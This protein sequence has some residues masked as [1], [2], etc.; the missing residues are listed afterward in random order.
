[1]LN[2]LKLYRNRILGSEFIQNVFYL[3]SATAVAQLIPFIALPFLQKYFYSPADFGVFTVYVVFSELIISSAS[4]KYEYAIVGEKRLKNSSNLLFLSLLTVLFISLL[5]FIVLLLLY[6]LRVEGNV[7][8]ILGK[9]IFLVP[10]SVAAYGMFECFN[11][12][13]NRNQKFF[14]I[15]AGKAILSIGSESTKII[16]G[17]NNILSGLVLGRVT[18]QISGMLLHLIFFIR[19]NS[20]LIKL[21]SVRHI[22]K[23]G[24][25]HK[26]LPLFSTPS[27]L[28]GALISYIYINMF[29]SYYGQSVVGV[30]GVSVSY[31]A[32]AFSML[33]VS[34][35]QVFYR[36]ISD[37]GDKKALQKLYVRY[38]LILGT[39]SLGV[40]GI[41]YLIPSSLVNNLLGERWLGLMPVM[42]TMVLW[43]AIAFVTSSL[44]FIYIK[45]SR[46]KEMFLLDLLH[47]LMVVA[48]IYLAHEFYGNFITTLRFFT[49]AQI[50][51]YSIALVSALFFLRKPGKLINTV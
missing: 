7:F 39:L 29:L 8:G 49:G 17:L 46:Q 13:L 27:V 40:V 26:N 50:I 1:L 9:L 37:I 43:M 23:M 5:T 22:K 36:K 6:N 19:H 14:L 30:I 48:S 32:A 33:S 10:V 3:A 2:T 12:W 44:S 20:S 25:K 28:L 16:F 4:L 15:G 35:A 42:R 31:V 41:I 47:L 45:L 24:K 38:G 18:G 21:F 11:Y 34:F 51:Y